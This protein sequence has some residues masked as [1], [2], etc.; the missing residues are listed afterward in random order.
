MEKMFKVELWTS[1]SSNNYFVVYLRF[2]QVKRN[3]RKPLR[4]FVI[5]TEFRFV[6]L[7]PTR[8]HKKERRTWAFRSLDGQRDGER[9]L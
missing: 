5:Q 3:F 8:E 6:I 9:K 4:H 2:L 1:R 7:E